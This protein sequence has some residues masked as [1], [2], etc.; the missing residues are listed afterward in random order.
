MDPKRIFV[1][2]SNEC[3]LL[4]TQQTPSDAGTMPKVRIAERLRFDHAIEL[5]WADPSICKQKGSKQWLVVKVVACDYFCD[6]CQQ[7]QSSSPLT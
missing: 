7:K 2:H 6:C 1:I 3:F 5:E 4:K